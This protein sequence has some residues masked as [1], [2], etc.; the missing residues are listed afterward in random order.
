M[1]IVQINHT[2][3]DM[4]KAGWEAR[5]T[6]ERAQQFLAVPGLAPAAE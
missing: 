1:V 6:P 3:P 5:H 4:P 2:R